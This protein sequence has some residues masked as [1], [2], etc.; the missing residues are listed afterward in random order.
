MRRF[1]VGLL[2]L[3]VAGIFHSVAVCREAESFP[4]QTML[5]AHR[6]ASDVAPENTVIAV[7]KAFD[8]GADAV[9]IDIW[10]SRDGH[11]VVFHDSTT[12]RITGIKRKIKEL[13]LAEI[14]RLD[15]GKW[16][17]KEFS[18]ERIPTLDQVLEVR[19]D[20]KVIVIEIKDT[21]PAIVEAL[22][23]SLLRTETDPD[24]AMI[25]SSDYETLKSAKKTLPEYSAYLL[26]GYDIR[27]YAENPTLEEIM[28]RCEAANL[29]G[30][31]FG[32]TWPIDGALVKRINDAGM[33]TYVWTVNSR[34][35]ARG[36]MRAGITGITSDRVEMIMQ[37][38]NE[39]EG[40]GVHQLSL[41]D[42]MEDF[43]Y[44][45]PEGIKL[46]RLLLVWFLFVGVLLIVFKTLIG[47]DRMCGALRAGLVFTVLFVVYC[48]FGSWLATTPLGVVLAYLACT[49]VSF[50]IVYYTYSIKLKL[51]IM[52]ASSL[53]LLAV[54]IHVLVTLVLGTVIGAVLRI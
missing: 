30:I 40:K 39:V 9:E 8:L 20:G 11:P 44:V 31:S 54:F 33:K 36:L 28:A 4:G 1:I 35:E 27:P 3:A 18:G 16:K 34:A 53:P 17:G 47:S 46:K 15:G 37:V 38:R 50:A 13:T 2:V 51:R 14:Q 43:H 19:P 32:R 21:D 41:Q 26:Q 10:L 7:E 49:A 25:I 22:V 42:R 12:D 23:S 24:S 48:F 52:F 29:D 45:L 6:G 5:I